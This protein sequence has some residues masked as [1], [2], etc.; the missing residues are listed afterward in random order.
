MSQHA[1][2]VHNPTD[3]QGAEFHAGTKETDSNAEPHVRMWGR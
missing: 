1:M 2:P 3:I